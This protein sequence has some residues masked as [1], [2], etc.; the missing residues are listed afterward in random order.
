MEH[1]FFV[2]VRQLKGCRIEFLAVVLICQ[3]NMFKSR[4]HYLVLKLS[5]DL[6]DNLLLNILQII[7]KML[8]Q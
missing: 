3:L 4:K 2:K 5:F 7:A 1:S 6:G 8:C